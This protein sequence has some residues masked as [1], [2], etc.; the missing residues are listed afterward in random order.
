MLRLIF[1]LLIAPPVFSQEIIWDISRI[2]DRDECRIEFP[3][4]VRFRDQWFCA[5]RE[6]I[7]HGND[8]S[9]RTRLIRSVDGTSWETAALFEWNGGDVRDP[10]LSITAEGALMLTSCIA[11][12]E[13]AG[14]SASD[15]EADVIR[16]SI[17]WLSRDGAVWGPAQACPTGVNTWRWD[18]TWNRGMGYSVA[19]HGTQASGALYRTRDGRTWRMLKDDF[20]P[21]SG[22]S[23]AALAFLGKNFAVCLARQPST[24]D[25]VVDAKLGI[26]RE[27]SLQEWEWKKIQLDWNGVATFA[28]PKLLVLRDG[29]LVATGRNMGLWLVDPETAQLTEI[30]KPAG[31]SYPGLVEHDGKLWMTGGTAK[32]DAVVFKAFDLPE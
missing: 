30:G 7:V 2:E 6:G 9:G 20:F 5:F 19:Y 16:Q 31:N 32:A 15:G 17:T 29:R 27:P 23:E 14:N 12:V 13:R 8:N 1:A 3:D 11:F 21:E 24:K 22:G 26:S 28:G 4:L 25:G 10:R 18:T